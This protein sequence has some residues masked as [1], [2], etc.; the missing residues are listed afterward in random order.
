MSLS[1]TSS[2]MAA[3]SLALKAVVTKAKFWGRPSEGLRPEPEYRRGNEC[4]KQAL[5][6]WR[7]EG[8]VQWEA[9]RRG[10]AV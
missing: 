4:R 7:K 6:C 9:K 8:E 10:G 3:E 5:C 2:F 1:L